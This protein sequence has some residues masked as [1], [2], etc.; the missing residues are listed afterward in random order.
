MKVQ[1]CS[2]EN[3]NSNTPKSQASP[4]FKA[5]I[6]DIALNAAGN[7]MQWIQDKGFLASFLIQDTLG[8]TVPRSAAGFLRDKEI[9][10]EYNMQ[11]GFEVIG[12]EG[13]TGPCMM[14]VAPIMMGLAAYCGKTT[15]VN[16]QLIK[17]YGNKF[18]EFI[19]SPKFNKALLN[20]KAKLKEEFLRSNIK[21][22]L[23]NS[24]GE[25]NFN[26]ETVN[27]IFKEIEN[28]QNAS[29]GAKKGKVRDEAMAKIISYINEI[30]LKTSEDLASLD[31]VKLGSDKLKDIKE[32]STKDAFD[33]LMK[34][35]DDAITNN[36]D[37]ANLSEETAENI[38]NSALAKRFI[39][40][41]GTMATTLGVM[42]VLPKIY[43]KSNVS[44]SAKTAMQMKEAHKAEQAKTAGVDTK[45]NDENK[46]AEVSFKGKG[47][48]SILSK[49]GK[50]LSEHSSG[51]FASELE[52]N[53]HNFTN[54]LMAGLS[55]FGL[56][57]PR[58]MRAY[59]R[60]P[61]DE[62]GKRDLSEL[63]E[64]LIR[65]IASSLSVV[66]LV[67][68]F[69]RACVS[70]YENKSGFV[71][72]NKDRSRSGLK[73]ALDLI[74]PYSSSHVLSNNEIKSLYDN[75]TSKEKMNNFCK[76]I[77][78]N[79]GDIEK[80]ISKSEFINEIKD[81]LPDLKNLTRTQKNEKLM[82][83]F[84]ESVDEA[85][86]KKVMKGTGGSKNVNKI[87]SFARGLN[88]IPAMLVTFLISPY[89]LGWF[90]PKLTYAN[91]RRRQEK[92]LQQNDAQNS[93]NT[94]VKPEVKTVAA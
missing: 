22:I 73:A 71:L 49:F 52:Y 68:M 15:S 11:E 83:F 93:V 86:I 64:I 60:A 6:G 76:Y 87:M 8:M 1:R 34:Y 29:K 20:D 51:K 26:N 45:N 54:T 84:K 35:T 30:K 88:S 59:N 63:Y 9:T 62:N 10:G 74:N 89:V 18:K 14:A 92:A 57:A 78:K 94:Q 81:K 65:D 79:G 90:I 55:L 23:K 32:F 48:S 75:I 7:S 58:G 47:S 2:I 38:K 39:T 21:D 42:S 17:R 43:A 85:T 28:Y 70:A 80:I 44:P 50:F 31:K 53:G 82:K 4:N 46:S 36:K 13:L 56:L 66:F 12:R 33:A 19:S 61:K 67:P 25:K 5:G 41:V 37:I 24:V 40:N 91:T 77:E 16:S 72:M 27:L 69:T 3:N